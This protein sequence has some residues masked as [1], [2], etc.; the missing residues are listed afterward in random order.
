[1][2]PVKTIQTLTE[3]LQSTPA[4]K[5]ELKEEHKKGDHND[6]GYEGHPDSPVQGLKESPHA[7]TPNFGLHKCLQTIPKRWILRKFN[8]CFYPLQVS[9]DRGC[10]NITPRRSFRDLAAFKALNQQTEVSPIALKIVGL[11]FHQSKTL[12]YKPVSMHPTS[13]LATSL[14]GA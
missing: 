8:A 3:Q 7:T 9:S 4:G 11:A 13:H 2:V 1:V 6:C 10:S 5:D 12:S 14:E